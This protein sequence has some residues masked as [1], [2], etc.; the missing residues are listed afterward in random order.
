PRARARHAEGAGNVESD[1]LTPAERVLAQQAE[2]EKRDGV[3]DQVIEASVKERRAEQAPVLTGGDGR[4]EE[5]AEGDDRVVGVEGIEGD[6]NAVDE[7]QQRNEA[8]SDPRQPAH[9]ALEVDAPREQHV[10]RDAQR[11]VCVVRGSSLP[12]GV[13][14]PY[15]TR[16]AAGRRARLV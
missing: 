2:D 15:T 10:G 8:S 4:S 16:S 1:E 5:R 7:E 9:P 12:G 11:A 6:L 13:I 3:A 14:G